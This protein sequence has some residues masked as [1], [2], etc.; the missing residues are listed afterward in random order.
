ME[1]KE[2]RNKL[3]RNGMKAIAAKTNIPYIEITRM[4]K[5]LETKRTPKVII[6]TV[7]YLNDLEKE[8]KAY[9]EALRMAIEA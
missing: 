4:F 7:E 1:L 6:A 5:G 9:K 8:Q 3:P 2:L